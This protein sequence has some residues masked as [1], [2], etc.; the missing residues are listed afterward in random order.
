MRVI[1][2]QIVTP[3]QVWV[4]RSLAYYH[5]YDYALTY[6]KTSEIIFKI[7]KFFP[8]ISYS[9]KYKNTFTELNRSQP[10]ITYFGLISTY[11]YLTLLQY[12]AARTYDYICTYVHASPSCTVVSFC[13]FIVFLI[14]AVFC[15][16]RPNAQRQICS[17]S[18]FCGQCMDTPPKR[19]MAY[20]FIFNVYVVLQPKFILFSLFPSVLS[21]LHGNV[22]YME[23]QG[24]QSINAQ[25][26]RTTKYEI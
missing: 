22:I 4:V 17:N 8:K 1:L 23:I 26:G 16:I 21:R 19:R 15:R 12:A 3:R 24:K 10:Y 25:Q 7:F 20:I 5:F 11:L 2:A 14:P 6:W 9:R 13:S 18:K